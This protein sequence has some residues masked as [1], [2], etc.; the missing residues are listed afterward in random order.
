MTTLCFIFCYGF[1]CA[2]NLAAHRKHDDDWKVTT[3]DTPFHSRSFWIWIFLPGTSENKSKLWYF[4]CDEFR[5]LTWELISIRLGFALVL[6]KQITKKIYNSLWIENFI[7]FFFLLRISGVWG[8]KTWA[9]HFFLSIAEDFWFVQYTF[10]VY[11]IFSL[12]L[13]CAFYWDDRRCWD[14]M[15]S[16]HK[17][18]YSKNVENNIIFLSLSTMSNFAK[19]GQILRIKIK[20]RAMNYNRL[21]QYTITKERKSEREKKIPLQNDFQWRHR[22]HDVSS[23][24]SN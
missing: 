4:H 6:G 3:L 22:V 2:P 13:Q 1:K 10:N 14:F 9:H 23:R 24:N 11:A 7:P 17:L 19:H 20:R 18:P 21:P 8:K 15:Q 16:I 5:M 12:N